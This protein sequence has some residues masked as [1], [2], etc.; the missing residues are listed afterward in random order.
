MKI[1]RNRKKFEREVYF[2]ILLESCKTRR[3]SA[4]LAREIRNC[5]HLQEREFARR[6]KASICECETRQAF[7]RDKT[8][9]VPEISCKTCKNSRS[10]QMPML[11]RR[12]STVNSQENIIPSRMSSSILVLCLLVGTSWAFVPDDPD[13]RGDNFIGRYPN[14]IFDFNRNAFAPSSDTAQQVVEKFLARMT[15][16]LESKDVAVISGLF[17]PGFVFKGCKGTYDK[18]QI[19]GLLSRIPSGTQF[20]L[21]LKSVLDTGSSIKYTVV[22]SGFGPASIEANFVLNKIDQQLE[23]GE[24]PACQNSRFVTFRS[25]QNPA[26]EMVKKFL[27]R[28]TRSIESKDT[29]IILGLFQPRFWFRGCKGRYNKEQVVGM[30]TKIPAGIKFSFTLKSAVSLGDMIKYIVTITGIRA[31]PVDAEFM[32]HIADQKLI[33]GYIWDCPTSGFLGFSQPE[34][35]NAVV[36]RFLTSMKPILDSHKPALIGKLFDDAF[37]F[38]GCHG[39]Y[40]KT[41]AIA[42]I[43]SLPSGASFDFSLI[44]SKWN[45]QGQIEYT[46]YVSVPM[47]D[48]IQAQFVYCPHRNVLKSGSVPGC[49]AS[50]FNVFY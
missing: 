16:S 42:K 17:Q 25:V 23:C 39:T 12:N 29:S 40:T 37:I 5:E 41:Q 36:Q 46:V 2:S 24:I 8:R 9:Q 44:N 43:T 49:A 30:L 48:R 38:K 33:Y 21:T 15:R 6:D 32:L 28:V 3:K 50:R 20:T 11:A 27:A 35:S 10:S 13:F 31:T 1:S 7:M 19:I 14:D 18:T 45:N 4:S 22:S 26:E 47:M 34:D